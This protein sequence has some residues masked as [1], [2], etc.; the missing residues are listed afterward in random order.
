MRVVKGYFLGGIGAL[1]MVFVLR[2]IAGALGICAIILLS[3]SASIGILLWRAETGPVSIGW[4]HH[5]V[6]WAVARA[7]TAIDEADV[8]A[9]SLEKDHSEDLLKITISNVVANTHDGGQTLGFQAITFGLDGDDL[10]ASRFGPQTIDLKDAT[11]RIVRR[12][13]RRIDLDYGREGQGRSNVFQNLTGGPY[14]REAF[15]YA[16]LNDLKIAFFDE[17]TGEAWIAKRA[18]ANIKRTING[19][20]ANIEGDFTNEGRSSSLQFD[21]SYDLETDLIVAELDVDKAP[22]AKI[23][24]IFFGAPDGILTSLVSGR[25][26]ISISGD[27][28]VTASHIK[29]VAENGAFQLGENQIGVNHIALDM[30]FDAGRNEFLIEEAAF[31]TD[32]ARLSTNGIVALLGDRDAPEAVRFRLDIKDGQINA[33]NVFDG[34]LDL[35]A[36]SLAGE[37]ALDG[38]RVDLSQLSLLANGVE[39]G[40]ALSFSRPPGR[41]LETFGNIEIDG[42]IDRKSLLGLWPKEAA[43]AARNF[44]LN[45]IPQGE[46]QNLKATIK[47]DENALDESGILIDD[48]LALSFSVNNAEIRYA[49]GMTPLRGVSGI[50]ELAGN[51]FSFKARKGRVGDLAVKSGS[52]NIPRLRPKG[53]PATFKLNVEGD[54]GEVLRLLNEPPL[55]VLRS[56]VFTADQFSGAGSVSA[57]IIR[58][59]QRHVPAKDYRYNASAQFDDLTVQ[60]FFRGN[61]LGEAQAKISVET[62]KMHVTGEGNLNGSRVNIDWH[63]GFTGSG[64][65]TKFR[66][67]GP[68]DPQIGDV[69]GVPLR[70]VLRGAGTF[71]LSAIGDIAAIRKLR[72]RVDFTDAALLIEPFGWVKPSGL[73]ARSDIAADFEKDGAVDVAIT[74]EGVDIAGDGEFSLGAGG[75]LNS[76]HIENLRL[77]EV[78]DMNLVANRS[79]ANDIDVLVAGRRLDL[80]STLGYVF[81]EEFGGLFDD[82]ADAEEPSPPLLA[83]TKLTARLDDVI[84]RSGISLKDVSLDFHHGPERIAALEIAALDQDGQKHSLLLDEYGGQR[85][86]DA[87]TENIGSLLQGFFDVTSIVGGNGKITYNL[88]VAGGA[89]DEAMG[90]LEARDLRVANAPLLARIFAA[91]SLPGLSD[92]LTG[93]GIMIAEAYS[94]FTLD[95][96]NDVNLLGFRAS[97]PS[98]GITAAGGIGF[99]KE[100]ALS[101]NGSVA[102]VYAVNSVLG[103]APLIG[104][105]FVNRSGEGLIALSYNAVGAVSAPVVT[106]NPL[107]VLTPGVFRRMFEPQAIAGDEA[108]T[109]SLPE[110]E[111]E[112]P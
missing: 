52:V 2:L 54:A 70:R 12:K 74:I 22:V 68:I 4:A 14:F 49:P 31:D 23:A 87:H 89:P 63:Q 65:H 86:L 62:G 9:V 58:P 43:S 34:A 73:A 6:G 19:Y 104:D 102:P 82:N 10:L 79:D 72:A 21:V 48:A 5:I 55:R 39:F 77:G 41:R 51:S 37:V 59:N 27:G 106:V 25:G 50:G 75:A 109:D 20:I 105:I 108:L 98:V 100:G 44:I 96:N 111:G 57:E 94:T 61:A 28:N 53:F 32:L 69:I 11:L 85:K 92:L 33:E 42:A 76:A 99:G 26:E 91:G 7:S 97:G 84:L 80:S 36:G 45:N 67:T 56:G 35:G 8:G 95:D 88:G 90:K 46:F 1:S 47:V 40:G 16:R 17:A 103:H 29:G 112:G 38:T 15:K 81:S 83:S 93:E 24:K 60:D 13:N 110:P 101:L 107:S 64:D 66:V 3:I 18:S 30:N 78:I 71:D